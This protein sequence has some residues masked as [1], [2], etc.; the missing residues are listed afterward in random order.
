M[1]S[2]RNITLSD[3]LCEATHQAM[4]ENENVFVIGEGVTDP[5]AI[6][7]TTKDLVSKFGLDR[8]IEAP[9]AEN[10]LT[11]F[12][13]GSAMSGMKPLLIHQRVEF[14]LLS[15]EQIF[16]NAAKTHYVS[17]GK[18]SVPLV[19][20]MIIGRGWGQGPAHSQSLEPIFS[21]VPGL[22]VIMPSLAN[23]AKD[24]L[25]SALQEKIPTMFIEHRWCHYVTGDVNKSASKINLD[26]PKV[27]KKGKD[28]T[29]VAFSYMIYEAL[30]ASEI[31][32]KF[33]ISSEIIDLRIL[34]PLNLKPILES[35]SKTR[36]LICCDTGF[37][38]YGISAEISASIT[39]N[40]FDSLKKPVRRIGLPNRPTPSSRALAANYYPT[41]ENIIIEV[42]NVL[43]LDNNLF[44][45]MLN[46]LNV[47]K[48][49]MKADVPNPLFKG[50]F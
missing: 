46:E 16:N 14:A 39:E 12:C 13:I 23:D 35:V 45:K 34:K 17:A 15:V 6:F 42:K 19:I 10:G 5:K 22:R 9:L 27:I 36:T 50:P 8:V 40:L 4:N 38:E 33:D 26:G 47:K 18:H 28:I 30:L 48:P 1:N 44:D 21:Y 31:L 41:A 20:R 3:A 25:Y 43:D 37:R 2:S 11:G 24:M 29:V 32:E 49:N 7:G